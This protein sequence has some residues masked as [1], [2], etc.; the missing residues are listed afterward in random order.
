MLNDNA[1]KH[2]NEGWA[3]GDGS[4]GTVLA[5]QHVKLDSQDSHKIQTW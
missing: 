2:S 5:V 1:S 4:L 3:W